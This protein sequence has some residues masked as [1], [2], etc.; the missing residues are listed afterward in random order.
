VFLQS[1]VPPASSMVHTH[2]MD[3]RWTVCRASSHSLVSTGTHAISAVCHCFATR[4]HAAPNDGLCRNILLCQVL[5][6]C[7]FLCLPLNSSSAVR[8]Q[9]LK[10]SQDVTVSNGLSSAVRSQLGLGGGRREGKPYERRAEKEWGR[11]A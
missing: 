1:H 2:H 6:R 5:A 8:S 11:G 9:W 7:A 10:I 4:C 3:S